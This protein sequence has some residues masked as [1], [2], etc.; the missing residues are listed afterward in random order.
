ME[1]L[2]QDFTGL[3]TQERQKNSPLKQSIVQLVAKLRV[4]GDY[5]CSSKLATQALDSLRKD[6]GKLE[7]RGG[8]TQNEEEG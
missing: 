4:S 1:N 3:A 7:G 5:L 2:N 6:Y 8:R